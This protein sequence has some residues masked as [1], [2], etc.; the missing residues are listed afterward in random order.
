MEGHRESTDL[1]ISVFDRKRNYDKIYM[2]IFR[3]YWFQCESPKPPKAHHWS[4][5]K[6]CV[7]RMDHHWPW[8]NNWIGFM[9]LKLFIV[10]LFYIFLLSAVTLI[11]IASTL[12]HCLSDKCDILNKQPNMICLGA[13]LLFNCI[14]G[15]FSVIMIFSQYYYIVE[16][17]STIDRMKKTQSLIKN[18]KSRWEK[19]KEVFGG[20][21]SYK[22]FL[23]I[24]IQFELTIESQ[25]VL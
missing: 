12:G 2:S 8:M 6:R 5:C 20:D 7:A 15:L 21:F 24:P 1:E 13:A 18:K 22:W 16:D 23:P 3:N 9:N 11:I 4:T 25:Y 17:T 14:F 19:V 10:C